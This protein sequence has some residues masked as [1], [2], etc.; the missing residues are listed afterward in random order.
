MCHR[1]SF[2]SFSRLCQNK[3]WVSLIL[4]AKTCDCVF[5]YIFVEISFVRHFLWKRWSAPTFLSLVSDG[6]WT[7]VRWIGDIFLL[8]C[9][10]T[11]GTGKTRLSS[12]L[13]KKFAFDHLDISTVAKENDFVEEYDDEYECPVLDEDKVRM[14]LMFSTT[15]KIAKFFTAARLSGT[16]DG[17]RRENCRLSF[18][19][20]FPGKMV[21]HRLRD[22]VWQFDFIRST[23][24]K[25]NDRIF[26]PKKFSIDLRHSCFRY[27]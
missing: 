19:R 26:L 11:P 13:A 3:K 6:N 12:E 8:L 14:N 2:C 4:T 20:I 17:R 22:A 10:G 25:V 27:K 7:F 5:V 24:S 16:D 1:R 15:S 21:W 23:Y 9:L 18:V